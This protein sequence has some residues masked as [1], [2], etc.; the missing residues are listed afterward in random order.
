MTTSPSRPAG[1]PPAPSI[2]E[3]DST[4]VGRSAPRHRRFRYSMTA[5]DT[6]TSDSS[7]A[8]RRRAASRRRPRRATRSAN[9]GTLRPRVATVTVGFR[10][11]ASLTLVGS[12]DLLHQR[13]ADDVAL[14]EGDEPDAGDVAQ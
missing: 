7:D 14:R 1:A 2:C 5:S 12:D 4:S 11:A 6:R 10:T 8:G 9:P 3:N 13:V